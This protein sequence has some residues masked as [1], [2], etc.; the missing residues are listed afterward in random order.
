MKS[1]DRSAVTRDE[2]LSRIRINAQE[3]R[4]VVAE[5][6]RRRAVNGGSPAL[7][8][9]LLAGVRTSAATL[10]EQLAEH[11]RAEMV[12]QP[13]QQQ[14]A[15]AA[16]SGAVTIRITALGRLGFDCTPDGGEASLWIV[17]D[18]RTSRDCASYAEALDL[19]EESRGLGYVP[20]AD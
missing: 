3:G 8:A 19:A 15:C 16:R 10:R 2:L 9:W 12:L 7:D 4:E 17:T 18:G 20:A 6:E 13:V 11:D 1:I 5:I 14:Q